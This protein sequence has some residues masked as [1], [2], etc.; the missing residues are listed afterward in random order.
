VIVDEAH[1][2]AATGQGRHQRYDLLKGL[3]ES[4]TRHLVMLTATPHSGDEAAFFR[5]LGLL[6]P[7]FENW[8]RHR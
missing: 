3:S 4:K 2:C 8:P 7:D 5:L 1:T 6:H